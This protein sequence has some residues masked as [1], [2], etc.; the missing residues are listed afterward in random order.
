VCLRAITIAQA[1][2]PKFDGNVK[3]TTV[4][5][6][7]CPLLLTGIY[8]DSAGNKRN[9]VSVRFFNQTKERVIG[10]KVGFDGLDAVWDS[11]EMS[12]TFALAVTC[13]QNTTTRQ[14]GE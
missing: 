7:E 9:R 13:D 1:K 3:N 11:H 14:S 6:P 2:T 8:Q 12:K 4:L 10:I 5:N